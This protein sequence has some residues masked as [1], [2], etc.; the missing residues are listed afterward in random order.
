M[1][2]ETGGR[3]VV[4]KYSRIRKAGSKNFRYNYDR[5]LLEW[6]EKPSKEMLEDNDHW[7]AK[8]DRPLWDIEDG[9]V[10]IDAVGLSQKNWKESPR[11]WCGQYAEQIDIEGLCL[12]QFE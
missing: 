9:Y 4:M 11:Y 2:G 12:M 8:F 10:V 1:G 7:M 5:S 3:E 6:V